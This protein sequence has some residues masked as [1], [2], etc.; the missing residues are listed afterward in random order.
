MVINILMVEDS[1]DQQTLYTDAVEDFNSIKGTELIISFSETAEGAIS[2]LNNDKY[3]AVFLDLKLQE[4]PK[5]GDQ[6]SGNKVL[7][8]I[9]GN[10]QLRMVV[11]LVSGTL[12]VLSDDHEKLFENPL[13]RKFERDSDTNDILDDL[14]RVLKTGVT[15]ILGGQG[16][17]EELVNTIFFSHLSKGFKFWVDKNRD[18]EKEL[19]RYMALHLLEHLDTPE[20]NSN[21]EAAYFN[22]EFYIHP[23]IKPTVSCGDILTV[24]DKNY[25]VLT[26]SC[27]I[28]PR[29]HGEAIVYNVDIVI[30]ARVLPMV[31]EVFDE[32]NISYSRDQKRSEGKWNGFTTNHRGTSPKSRF[33]YLPPYLTIEESLIDFKRLVNVP[34]EKIITLDGVTRVATVSSPFI[35]D[36]Q[37]RFSSYYGR[38]GQ[39]VGE[40]SQ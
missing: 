28:A 13:M 11:Y 15:K 2:K 21:S 12:H 30:L 18:C 22:P 5:N 7:Q 6:A 9:V 4:D 8:H 20:D 31:K 23:P 36:I 34:I 10:S 26:P 39:P 17:F 33:H 27:D 3:D 29:S 24:D 38:H 16:K 37:G 40:W 1:Q 32:L 25:I 35:R 14:V 19:L